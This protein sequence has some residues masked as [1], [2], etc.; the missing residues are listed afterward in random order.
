MNKKM[1]NAL[2]LTSALSALALP[3][4]AHAQD[5]GNS[6]EDVASAGNSGNDIIVTA[7]RQ[8]QTLQD[9]PMAVDVLTGEDVAKM[10]I[11]DAKEVQNLAPGLQLSNNDGRSNVATLR[12]VTF[13]PDSGSA[14]AVEIFLNEVP[15]DAQTVFTAIYDVGQIEV[16]R[17]PQGLF[18]GRTSPAGAILI[19]THRADVYDFTGYGQVTASDQHA[20]NVQGAANLVVVPGKLGFRASMLYDKNRVGI[21]KRL[22]GKY[23][24]SETMSARGSLAYEDGPFKAD[25][26]YQYLNAD[27]NPYVAVFGQGNQP[28]LLLGDPSASGPALTLDDRTAVTEGEFR[29]QNRT[30]FVTLNANYDLGFGSLVYNGGYQNSLLNQQR[31]M[32]VANAVPNYTPTQTLATSYSIWNHELRL[33]SAPGSRLS[34]SIAGNYTHQ[35]NEI[36]LTQVNDVLFGIPGVSPIPPSSA[37]LRVNVEDRI[38]VLAKTYGLAGMVGYEFFDGLKLTAGLRHTW[39]NTDRSEVGSVIYPDL[40]FSTPL[41]GEQKLR[42]R[43]FTGGANLSW[44]ATPDLTLYASYGHSFRPAV[45]AVGVTVPLDESLTTT[46]DETSD[47]GEI[48]LKTT[49]LNRAVSLNL[50]AF[51]Q[52]F[53]NY[54]AYRPAITSD[55]DRNGIVDSGTAPLP[56]NGDAIS[57]G[58]EVQLAAHPNDN[59]DLGLNA[60]YADSH[61]DNA[62]IICNDYNGDGLPDATGTP[63]VQPG[64]QVSTCLTDDRLAQVPKF[65]LN[66][67]AELRMPMGAV[68]P[69][70]RTLVNYRP[71]FNSELDNYSYRAYTKVDLFA[72]LR[73]EDGRWELTA[74]AKNLLDQTR[75][76]S[77]SA[78]NAVVPT[79]SPDFTTAGPA[80]DSGYRTAVISPPREIGVT[81]LFRW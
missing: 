15:T 59:I 35:R 68:T 13:D 17:G 36:P 14:P 1:A 74:Y 66:G 60:S 47:G 70:V 55:S 19:G 48:G 20:V 32:D 30:H 2:M 33:E 26:T 79:S 46:K 52:K 65:S 18:R 22:D 25:L 3:V 44:E 61:Y 34:W 45:T 24:S 43:A 72:G 5:A 27:T 62:L 28:A 8:S 80:F 57:K 58:F 75:A 50:A 51:Y 7:T 56:F 38:E 6:A 40:G 31:D 23:S 78:G 67:S 64:K 21:V 42:S 37:L 63:S 69:F 81:A 73:G 39:Y 77:V 49:F 12:G 53:S 16:L 71:G 41:G 9:T 76:L 10:N 11:F 29:F 4:M 54:I